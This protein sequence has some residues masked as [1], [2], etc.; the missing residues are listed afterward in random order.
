MMA[1]ANDKISILSQNLT[2]AGCVIIGKTN[3]D[4]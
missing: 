3:T 2:D 4:E 1:E